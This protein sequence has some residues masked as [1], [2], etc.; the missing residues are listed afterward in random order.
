MRRTKKRNGKLFAL[1]LVLWTGL[2]CW[3]DEYALI[4]GTVFRS[5]GHAL[6]G[7]EVTLQP[8]GGKTQKTRSSP[9]GEFTF[10]VPAKPL[11]Y[12]VT[13]KAA[14]FKSESKPVNVQADERVDLT[15]LL[16][17]EKQ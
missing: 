15:F 13:V 11:R 12:T 2:P 5:S 10:R 3:A 17:N 1:V 8:E 6:S 4:F 9:R 16:E 7:A 14:G